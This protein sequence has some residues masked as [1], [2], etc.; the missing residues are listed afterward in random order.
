[1]SEMI[2]PS[3]FQR[4]IPNAPGYEIDIFGRVFLYGKLQPTWVMRDSYFYVRIGR[5]LK[6]L[7][8]LVLEAF[9]GSAPSSKHEGCHRDGN[10]YNNCLTNL[11]WGT[12]ADNIA[13]KVRHGTTKKKPGA[14]NTKL[15]RQQILQ[16]KKLGST[17]KLK[18]KEI[19]QKFQISESNA[20]AIV[21][22]KYWANVKVNS[23]RKRRSKSPHIQLELPLF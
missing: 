21:N 9:V 6:V 15:N 10:R 16:I 11:T 17:G 14:Q 2:Q 7:H 19:A 4:P 13:D 12:R 20:R 22:G 5:S 18:I 3:L 23:S 1:M 8:R